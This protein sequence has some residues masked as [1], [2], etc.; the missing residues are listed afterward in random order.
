[1][2]ILEGRIARLSGNVNKDEKEALEKQIS[3]LNEALEEEK[4]AAALLTAQSKNLQVKK[5]VQLYCII[6]KYLLEK[7]NSV[8]NQE[9]LERPNY[10]N[11]SIYRDTH[12][13]CLCILR[14]I[15][16]V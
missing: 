12:F 3:E 1:M 8:T 15:S 5:L 2:H 4:K 10:R 11:I 13:M 9:S 6:D 14:M 16:A 7:C